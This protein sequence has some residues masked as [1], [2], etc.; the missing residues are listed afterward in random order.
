MSLPL[1][2]KLNDDIR[3]ISLDA[4]QLETLESVRATV[5]QLY[6]IQNNFKIQYRDEG[7]FQLFSHRK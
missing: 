2:F 6:K 5:R 1:K 7:L 3:R 4:K